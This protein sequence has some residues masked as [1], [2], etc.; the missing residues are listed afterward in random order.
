MQ[1]GGL[2]EDLRRLQ[3]GCGRFPTKGQHAEKQ[4]RQEGPARC[5][6]VCEIAVECW[7]DERRQ[8]GEF[9]FKSS[10]SIVI[11]ME[12]DSCTNSPGLAAS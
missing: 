1:R 2:K 5:S 6:E 7:E 8:A 4:G 10:N 9:F 3:L 11:T 12:E